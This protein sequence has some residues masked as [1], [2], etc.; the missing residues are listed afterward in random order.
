VRSSARLG[1]KRLQTRLG[2]TPASAEPGPGRPRCGARLAHPSP[3]SEP[4]H[5]DA[6]GP[7]RDLGCR[8]PRPPPLS[9]P[10]RTKWTRLVHPSVL[11]GHD[12][13]GRGAADVEAELLGA[14][15]AMP[16]EAAGGDAVRALRPPPLLKRGPSQRALL[17]CPAPRLPHPRNRQRKCL[18]PFAPWRR[19]GARGPRQGVHAQAAG[20]CAGQGRCGQSAVCAAPS[21]S[22]GEA[23]IT[24]WRVPCGMRRPRGASG[25]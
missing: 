19:D 5:G 24:C 13:G 4:L 20:R 25:A 8:A 23:Q 6:A 7:S 15:P 16:D 3:A 14:P 11:I 18:C 1:T 22:A 10:S 17:R 21:Q 12:L 9:P 2:T